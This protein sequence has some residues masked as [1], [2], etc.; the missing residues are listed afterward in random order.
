MKKKNNIATCM[1]D[2]DF[3]WVL[4]VL[5]QK[6]NKPQFLPEV[7]PAKEPLC[8]FDELIS[9]MIKGC[10]NHIHYMFHLSDWLYFSH[11][12]RFVNVSAN[13][14]QTVHKLK[15]GK[16][17]HAD[18]SDALVCQKLNFYMTSLVSV[19]FKLKLVTQIW[20]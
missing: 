14:M 15:A 13:I 3:W 12:L 10:K 2:S 16:P 5:K 19:N 1:L 6:W 4:S 20:N 17:T 7:A 9:F 8:N 11:W 18:C